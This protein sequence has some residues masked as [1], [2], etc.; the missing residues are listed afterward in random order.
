MIIAVVSKKG[1]VGKTTTTVCLA[2]ALAERGDRVLLADLD[3]QASA[4]ISLGVRR[5]AL[6]PSLADVLLWETPVRQAIRRTGVPRLDLL[7]ASADLTSADQELGSYRK[8]EGR[9]AA[10]L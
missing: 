2:A 1:G 7:T 10:A 4:S 9:L 8:S 5:Q 3:S 6:A